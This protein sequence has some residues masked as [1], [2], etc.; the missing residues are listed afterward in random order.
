MERVVGWERKRRGKKKKSEGGG[1]D[2]N[3]ATNRR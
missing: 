1:E 2:T 3:M